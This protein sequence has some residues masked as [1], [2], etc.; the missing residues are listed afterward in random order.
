MTARAGAIGCVLLGLYASAGAQEIRLSGFGTS[1][2]G[3]IEVDEHSF[4][5]L[6]GDLGQIMGAKMLGP[7]ETTGALGFDIGFE[8]SVSNIDEGS[9]HWTKALGE[10]AD[11]TLTTVQ[12]QFRKG[13]PFSFELGGAVTHLVESDL[14]GVGMHL[15]YAVLEGFRFIPDL[16]IRANISTVLGSRD[17]SMLITGGD[18]TVSK[19]FGLGGV[20][21]LG[22]YAGYSLMFVRAS[23]FV[24]GIFPDDIPQAQKFVIQGQSVIRHRGF[25]GFRLVTVHA[26]V[27]FEV[28]LAGGIQTFTTKVGVDF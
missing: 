8:V 26:A 12:L 28:M 6:A 27:A 5:E 9:T 10:G 24:L 11:S 22:P 3:V 7:A 2:Q 23:S 4:A 19:T 17:M 21:S 14:W 25:L 16:A 18:L 15:K 1:S 20:L 13:L